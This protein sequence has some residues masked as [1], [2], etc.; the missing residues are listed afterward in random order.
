MQPLSHAAQRVSVGAMHRTLEKFL[1]ANDGPGEE[2]FFHLYLRAQ[3]IPSGP[4]HL[5]D[6]QR[7]ELKGDAATWGAARTT[8]TIPLQT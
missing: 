4:R 7:V 5:T 6:E 1:F 3:S 2:F 8:A